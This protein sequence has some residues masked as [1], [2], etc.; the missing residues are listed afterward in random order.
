MEVTVKIPEGVEFTVE[1]Q[2][3]KTVGPEGTVTRVFPSSRL[4]V[5]K[6]DG[7]ITVQ[8]KI[9]NSKTRAIVKTF[10][11]HIENMLNGAKEPFVYKLKAASVHFPMNLALTGNVF[12]ITNF[13]G[14]K[15]PIE[16]KIP[17]EAKVEVKG[18]D[19]T[20]TSPNIEIAGMV[21]TRL[22]QATRL[23]NKDRR[24][25]QDGIFITH[26]AGKPVR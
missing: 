7:S 3:L 21:A 12:K 1:G 11:K 15:K 14:S 8:N 20:V 9:E 25:F 4:K 24:V 23:S 22:E 6:K 18:L 5:V 19:I 17:P 16:V 26:K 13:L 10:R 2:T